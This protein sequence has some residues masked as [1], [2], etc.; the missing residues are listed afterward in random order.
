M[1]IL[2]ESGVSSVV[3]PSSDSSEA[4][5]SSSVSVSSD[6]Y[7]SSFPF[8]DS[9]NVAIA[10]VGERPLLTTDFSTYTV[11]EGLLLIIAVS[12]LSVAAIVFF[13]GVGGRL[14]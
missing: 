7:S 5:A 10:S 12:I 13:K 8:S 14:L 9:S 3:L 6:V 4:S 2:E 11:V 1:K